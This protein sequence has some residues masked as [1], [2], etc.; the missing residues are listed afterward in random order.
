MH[1]YVETHL[2]REGID[3]FGRT[4][5]RPAWRRPLLYVLCTFAY[6]LRFKGREMDQARTQIEEQRPP[7]TGKV[8]NSCSTATACHAYLTNDPAVRTGRDSSSGPDFPLTHS[9]GPDSLACSE[10]LSQSLSSVLLP[11]SK[12]SPFRCSFTTARPSATR[13]GISETMSLTVVHIR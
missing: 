1:V 10:P 8:N 3:C 2:A 13:P 9:P 12:H 5:R 7:A 11:V 6:T 4:W